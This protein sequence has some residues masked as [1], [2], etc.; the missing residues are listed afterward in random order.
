MMIV[1]ASLFIAVQR[2]AAQA[3]VT[4]PSDDEVLAVAKKLYCPVCPNTP[5][6][7]CETQACQDWRAQGHC[8]LCEGAKFRGSVHLCSIIQLAWQAVKESLEQ[9]DR[10]AIGKPWQHQR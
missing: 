10:K 8:D 4:G 2:V 9:E 6:D 1:A 7:V 5:L 3:A